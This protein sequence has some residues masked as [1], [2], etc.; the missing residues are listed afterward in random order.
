M[1]RTDEQ[2]EYLKTLAL[3]I[4]RELDKVDGILDEVIAKLEAEKNAQP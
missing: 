4:L 1:N 3:V 2:R